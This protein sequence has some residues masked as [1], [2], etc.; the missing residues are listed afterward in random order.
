MGKLN[1]SPQIITLFS[2]SLKN[3]NFYITHP[4]GGWRKRIKPQHQGVLPDARVLT[5]TNLPTREALDL[6]KHPVPTLHDQEAWRGEWRSFNGWVLKYL[7][8][9]EIPISK[10]R[11][12][13][14][15]MQALALG[16]YSCKTERRP[17]PPICLGRQIEIRSYIGNKK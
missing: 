3:Y 11:H 14:S 5:I 6:R 12:L 8:C 2:N 1:N 15:A 13:A 16:R 4:P 9:T 10:N 17:I 7:A